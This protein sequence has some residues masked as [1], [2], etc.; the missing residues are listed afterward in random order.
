M[1]ISA[2]YILELFQRQDKHLRSLSLAPLI[3]N[4]RS[5]SSETMNGLLN[6]CW[7]IQLGNTQ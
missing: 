6:I 7:F 5:W 4:E 1:W 3:D 2:Y